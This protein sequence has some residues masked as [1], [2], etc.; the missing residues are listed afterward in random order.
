MPQPLIRRSGIAQ[1][2]HINIEE[3]HWIHSDSLAWKWTMFQ[4][5]AST[6]VTIGLALAKVLSLLASMLLWH[7]TP[8]LLVCTVLAGS[9][10]AN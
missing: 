7:S 4:L 10:G 8:V 6:Y 3:A 9:V 1:C 2:S 5:L